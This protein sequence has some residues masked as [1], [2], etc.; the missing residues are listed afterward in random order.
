MS[1][2]NA[3]SS[4]TTQPDSH[5]KL[6]TGR[7]LTHAVT[8]LS[9]VRTIGFVS[10]LAREFVETMDAT[11]KRPALPLCLCAAPASKLVG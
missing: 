2:G 3:S 8:T 7:N 11:A 5:A 10:T 1:V 4:V 6:T 9:I